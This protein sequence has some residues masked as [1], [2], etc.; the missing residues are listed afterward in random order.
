MKKRI[1]SD[2]YQ[3]NFSGPGFPIEDGYYIRIDPRLAYNLLQ[4]FDEGIYISTSKGYCMTKIDPNTLC[5]FYGFRSSFAFYNCCGET[6]YLTS[7]WCRIGELM[8][9]DYCELV[10]DYLNTEKVRYS[11][12]IKQYRIKAKFYE[13]LQQERMKKHGF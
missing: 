11:T 13:Q 9:N 10:N 12:I 4:D 2:P 7:F 5:D 6:G 8:Y 1:I 3:N